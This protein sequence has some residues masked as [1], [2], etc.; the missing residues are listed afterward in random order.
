MSSWW[1]KTNS[2]SVKAYAVIFISILA[3]VFGIYSVVTLNKIN[4]VR[5]QV[6]V[7]YQQSAR[8]EIVQAL[9]QLNQKLM[10]DSQKFVEWNETYQQLFDSSYYDYWRGRVSQS[11]I[12]PDTVRAV[13]LFDQRG[14]PIAKELQ[15]DMSGNVLGRARLSVSRQGAQINGYLVR[16]IY[17]GY[18]KAT[19]T[20]YALIKFDFIRTL[21]EVMP[22]QY[23]DPGHLGLALSEGQII[24]FDHVPAQ[25]EYRLKR[26]SD[27]NNLFAV[28]F[29]DRYQM[30]LVLFMLSVLLYFALLRFVARPLQ[31]LSQHIDALK[32]NANVGH[33]PDLHQRLPILELEHVRKSLND[34]QQ[35]I[36]DMHQHID[37]KNAELWGMAH[38][39]SL[40]GVF[41]RRS[42]DE[43][44]RL[45]L[46]QPFQSGVVV[47]LLLFDCD[48]FK[49]INDTYGHQTG[50]QVLIAVA[51]A[52][53]SCLRGSDK[54]YRIGGDEFA[55]MFVSVDPQRSVEV[56]NRCVAMVGQCDFSIWGI[57][58]PVR[59]SVGIAQ[60]TALN[61]HELEQL[62]KRADIAMYHA[63][64]PGHGKVV[65]YQ[66]DMEALSKSVF[67][68]P[69]TNAVFNAI[70]TGTGLHIHYQPVLCLATRQVEYYEALVR[71]QVGDE[72][73]LPCVIFPVVY[74]RHLEAGFDFA[75]MQRIALDLANRLIPVGTGVSINVSGVSVEN[76]EFLH[77]IAQFTPFLESYKLVLE[78]TET[79]LVTRL[80]QVSAVL[81]E[82][83]E[84]G[85]VIALDDFG[86]G[87]S[88]LSY[89]A[90]MPVDIVKFDL[91]MIRSL[92]QGGRQG[93]VIEG[94]ARIIAEAGY[95]L[96]AEGI[97]TE[98]TLAIIQQ[99][100]FSHGQGY[101]F[102]AAAAL[103]LPTMPQ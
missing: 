13:E 10:Q 38:R 44:C 97:E 50:D 57:V 43:D 21:V 81:R 29:R 76:L 98:R 36:D 55:V 30:A 59:I 5:H 41:N 3:T 45:L 61:Q 99:I 82:L 70:Q 95:T 69:L 27:I 68:N 17:D 87:Y 32:N 71:L 73:V 37:E 53:Q 1:G 24:D 8:L 46:L 34:Y 86:S 19:P 28:M 56:A 48:Y 92:E 60:T 11:G 66:T 89:I 16:P 40:T 15:Q 93:M 77:K 84:T 80:Q 49:S 74:A 79:S 94:L 72:L 7:K 65:V 26:N 39:D 85:F 18:S 83:R 23:V 42:F 67:S 47:G 54:L 4:M 20:G 12:L 14:K 64:L 2:L 91:S 9:M 52:M 100:G 51:N 31:I 103:E 101:L 58:D 33:R 88:S 102:G 63:K 6:E 35:Q 96:V 25:I 62:Q 22:F 90:N 78:L 75:I